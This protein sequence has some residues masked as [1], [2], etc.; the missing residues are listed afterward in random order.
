M[1][2][3]TPEMIEHYTRFLKDLDDL[4][5]VQGL[6]NTDSMFWMVVRGRDTPLTVTEVACRLGA[7]PSTI[8]PRLPVDLPDTGYVALEQSEHGVILIASVGF[9]PTTP[10]AWARLTENAQAWGFWW[11]INNANEL[12]YG[13]DGALVTRLDI[14]HPQLSGCTGQNPQG[15]EAYLGAL[16]TLAKRKMTDDETGVPYTDQ[17]RDWE[18]AL[19]TVEA[20]SG[21]RLDLDRL[22]RE[23]QSVYAPALDS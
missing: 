17:Y 1:D 20:M 13:A 3:V 10:E 12:C 16:R 6:M 11:L 22:V 14:L 23:Q 4:S 8:V 21:V 18:T 7:D 5:T 2:P 19:A 9:S 15:L